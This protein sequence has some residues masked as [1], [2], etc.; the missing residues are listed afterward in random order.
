[1]KH[2]QE[3]TATAPGGKPDRHIQDRWK[4]LNLPDGAHWM[5]VRAKNRWEMH[6]FVFQESLVEQLAKE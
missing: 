6:G 5:E 1:M 3:A 4:A 2:K